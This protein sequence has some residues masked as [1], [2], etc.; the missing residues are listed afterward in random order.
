MTSN[1]LDYTTNLKSGKLSEEVIDAICTA[2]LL[3]DFRIELRYCPKAAFYIERRILGER[4]NSF[5]EINHLTR[6]AQ[7]LASQEP[8]NASAQDTIFRDYVVRLCA[9][10]NKKRWLFHIFGLLDVRGC[11]ARF[12]YDLLT[13]AAAM[14]KEELVAKL[15][16]SVNISQGGT[17]EGSNVFIPAIDAKNHR[18]LDILFENM[19]NRLFMDIRRGQILGRAAS[20]GQIETVN[21]VMTSKWAPPSN[22]GTRWDN[23]VLDKGLAT[24]SIQIFKTIVAAREKLQAKVGIP[25]EKLESLL[26]SSINLG[27]TDMT[28]HLISIGAPLTDVLGVPGED[29]I[30]IIKACKAGYTDIVRLLLDH[31]A[32]I[33]EKAIIAAARHGHLGLVEMFHDY[34]LRSCDAMSAA[35]QGGH[36]SI[37]RLLVDRGEDVNAGSSPPVVSAIQLENTAMFRYLIERGAVLNTDSTGGK[38]ARKAKAAGLESMLAL[39]REHDVDLPDDQADDSNCP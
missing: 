29:N 9:L 5:P 23:E 38:A 3:D 35:A 15:G 25:Q 18:I 32:N 27:W 13:A 21:H 37:V 39:L 1:I 19:K 12:Q 34:D 24:P 16:D 33:T 30:H 31:G 20:R 10:L 14:D 8:I 22:T 7:T 6:I 28:Q 11:E 26:S 2:K 36:L 17:F 4:S